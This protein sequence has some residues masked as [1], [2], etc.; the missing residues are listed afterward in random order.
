MNV[1]IFI[2]FMKK[3]DICILKKNNAFIS[4]FIQG[5]K[6]CIRMVSMCQKIVFSIRSLNDVYFSSVSPPTF[7]SI[8]IFNICIYLI[9]IKIW[10]KD[11]PI[12]LNF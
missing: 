12:Y 9:K 1:L 5:Y 3:A 10:A 8:H 6:E 11:K 7:F 4:I 2:D